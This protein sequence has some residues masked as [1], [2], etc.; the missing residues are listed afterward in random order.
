MAEGRQ[1]SEKG[2]LNDIGPV[3]QVDEGGTM[4][5][6]YDAVDVFGWFLS[7]FLAG[8]VVINLY[9]FFVR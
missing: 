5:R 6:R 8:I 7:G 4:R 2:W 3:P 1:G 9:L